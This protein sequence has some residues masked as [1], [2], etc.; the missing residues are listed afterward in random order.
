MSLRGTLFALI[1][2]RQMAKSE[3]AGLRRLREELLAGA[4]G[5]VWECPDLFPLP[6]PNHPGQQKWMLVVNL[7]PGA[8]AGGQAM[9]VFVRPRESLLSLEGRLDH[10]WGRAQTTSYVLFGGRENFQS[11]LRVSGSLPGSFVD[12]DLF[13]PRQTVQ[14]TSFLIWAHSWKVRPGPSVS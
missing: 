13:E 6:D 10:R 4:T 1:Y 14:H 7:N 3:R 2:D 9:E 8:I 5:R 11:P 12:L